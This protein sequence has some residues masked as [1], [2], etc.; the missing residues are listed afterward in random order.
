[1]IAKFSCACG[2]HWHV[3]LATAGRVLEEKC[4]G[5]KGVVTQ[6]MHEAAEFDRSAELDA[7]RDLRALVLGT[8]ALRL[9]KPAGGL[10]ALAALAATPREWEAIVKSARSA[11]TPKTF[12]PF[13]KCE[14]TGCPH[15]PEPNLK[16][17][18]GHEGGF[19]IPIFPGNPK[20]GSIILSKPT[21]E[22][23]CSHCSVS[24]RTHE[25]QPPEHCP[26][27]YH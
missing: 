4:P 19:E 21:Y 27:C 5:C 23:V 25:P 20:A 6:G 22:H 15:P 18:R 3:D 16:R 10:A 17:C 26:V 11:M 12:D 8:E 14:I 13:T 7:L 9:E 1:M 2:H 24:S